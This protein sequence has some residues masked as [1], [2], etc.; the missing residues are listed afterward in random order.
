MKIQKL[1]GLY[2]VIL[3]FS[4][5]VLWIMILN[6]NSITEGKTEMSFHL[7]SEFLMAALCILS[8]F[9]ILMKHRGAIPV[10]LVAH[11]MVIYSLLN[12]AGY[13]GERGETPAMAF[14]LTIL[15]ISSAIIFYNIFY[16]K[17]VT[18]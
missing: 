12:A 10:N 8:G 16:L 17:K 1:T 2:S 4:I 7:F 13:Y 3:G 14:F 15:L 11:S 18:R 5:V 9:K 6:G